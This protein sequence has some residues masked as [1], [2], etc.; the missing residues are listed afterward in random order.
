MKINIAMIGNLIATIFV[1]IAVW[2]STQ[3]QPD[4]HNDVEQ[5]T[6]LALAY[7]AGL[8]TALSSQW[9][10]HLE[11]EPND[12]TNGEDNHGYKKSTN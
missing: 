12:I 7:G 4:P 8:L 1:A 2:L 3:W 10:V 5:L 11:E 9:T 6:A